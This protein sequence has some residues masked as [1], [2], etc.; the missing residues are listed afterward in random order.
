MLVCNNCILISD[1]VYLGFYFFR[2]FIPKKIKNIKNFKIKN[3]ENK[4]SHG[5]GNS[6]KNTL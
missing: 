1:W 4:I 3:K 5:K 6:P 2:D